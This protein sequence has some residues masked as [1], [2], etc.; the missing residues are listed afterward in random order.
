M[1]NSDLKALDNILITEYGI[2]VYES[3]TKRIGVKKRVANIFSDTHGFTLVELIVV[4]VIIAILAAAIGPA[5]LGYIDKA[6]KN[7]TLND[8]KKVYLA[9]QSI[10]EQAHNDYVAPDITSDSA[11]NRISEITDI[12][13]TDGIPSYT[14]TFAKVF[15]DSNPTNEMYK[16]K[17]FTYNDGT[18]TA[19]YNMNGQGTDKEIWTIIEN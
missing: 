14:V 10:V 16:I 19:Q 11:K 12:S 18:F 3:V 13:F 5:F 8:A 17:V 4:L 6:R 2:E 9:A 15:V 7:A 1:N